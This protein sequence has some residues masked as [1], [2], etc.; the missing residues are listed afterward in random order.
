VGVPTYR[1]H[2]HR[3][4]AIASSHL[5]SQ[6]PPSAHIFGTPVY[7]YLHTHRTIALRAHTCAIR[8]DV[9]THNCTQGWTNFSDAVTC[10]TTAPHP[11][12]PRRLRRASMQLHVDRIDIAWDSPPT[13]TTQL[14]GGAL[15][16]TEIFVVLYREAS[17]SAPVTHEK[18]SNIRCF[19]FFLCKLWTGL[20]VNVHKNFICSDGFCWLWLTLLWPTEAKSK[21]LS[22]CEWIDLTEHTP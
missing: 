11:L 19:L 4:T 15:T 8:T 16:N 18:H 17:V 7:A 21:V 3:H 9:R 13:S 12:A 14:D 10:G 22:F 2:T 20:A 1:P 6:P 5:P